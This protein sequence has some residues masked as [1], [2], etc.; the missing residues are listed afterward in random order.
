MKDSNEEKLDVISQLEK[1]EW[2]VDICCNVRFTYGS[3]WV[4]DNA[5]RFTE[6]AKWG[7]KVFVLQVYQSYQ[8]EPC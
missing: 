8:N 5:D 3:I 1:G 7:P 2:I 6:S 4:S